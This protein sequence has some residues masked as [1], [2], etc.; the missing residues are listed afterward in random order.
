MNDQI[1]AL[2][3]LAK[4]H[5]SGALT[6][7]EFA[8]QKAQLLGGGASVQPR[9]YSPPDQ[10]SEG[11][12]PLWL[13]LGAL[14][15]VG[16][17]VL[18]WWT[19]VDG[20]GEM[21]PVP[22]PGSA[23]AAGASASAS[24]RPS[25]SPSVISSSPASPAPTVAAAVV[26]QPKRPTYNPSFSCAGQIDNVLSMICQSRELSN[27]DRVLSDRFKAALR[28][29]DEFDKQAVLRRQR[30]FLRER[31]SCQDTECLHAWYDRVNEF[32]WN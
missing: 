24:T 23:A 30:A 7:A 19:M 1:D 27:K 12:Q 18:L 26:A 2:E 5:Q 9:V 28:P 25:A 21:K 4:L 14:A 6:D 3:R 32:Y 8:A 11:I 13:L 31:N 10:A 20:K 17:G 22:T 15:A 16:L 29:L